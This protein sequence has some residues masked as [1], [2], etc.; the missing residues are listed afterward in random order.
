ML[1][2]LMLFNSGYRIETI[3]QVEEET[4]MLHIHRRLVHSF[5]K[6]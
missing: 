1:I 4:R 3:G 5:E 2:G 6:P